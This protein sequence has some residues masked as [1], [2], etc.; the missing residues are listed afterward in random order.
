MIYLLET[1]TETEPETETDTE[2]ETENSFQ[3]ITDS[4]LISSPGAMYHLSVIFYSHLVAGW[5]NLHH[6]EISIC[7]FL[8]I[9]MRFL[10]ISLCVL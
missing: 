3:Y 5:N 2:T 6:L 9:L 1:E 4:W 10:K 7:D 8:N